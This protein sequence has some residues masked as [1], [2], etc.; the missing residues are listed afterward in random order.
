[1]WLVYHFVVTKTVTFSIFTFK[2]HEKIAQ[3]ICRF[4]SRLHKV[5][6]QRLIFPSFLMLY[7]PFIPA[8]G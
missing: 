2:S 4:F 5:V 6:L 3:I 8:F 1:M 7:L